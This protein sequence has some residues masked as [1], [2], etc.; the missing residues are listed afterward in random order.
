MNLAITGATS[1]IGIETVKALAPDFKDIFLLVRN[2]DKAEEL[3]GQWIE[4]G[5]SSNFHVISCDLSDLSTV[6]IA[7]EKIKALCPNLDVLINNA[8]GIFRDRQTTAD[9]LEWAFSVNHLGH[10]LLT[11]RLM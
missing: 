1:G 8:G 3:I 10:F 7:A 5:Y 2:S 6:A 11:Q 9:G 4:E